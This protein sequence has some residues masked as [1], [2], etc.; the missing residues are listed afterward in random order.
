[1]NARVTVSRRKF[2]HGATMAA[3]GAS[4]GPLG[5]QRAFPAD[6]SATPSWSD[7]PMRWAQ[8]TLVEDDPGKFDAR[9][10]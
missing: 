4:L 8:I 5:A 3:A 6:S 1:M 7:K 10:D 9:L 2:L